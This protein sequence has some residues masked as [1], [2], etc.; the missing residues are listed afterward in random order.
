MT[1]CLLSFLWMALF[2]ELKK[3]FMNICIDSHFISKVYMCVWG[4]EGSKA[5]FKEYKHWFVIL[6]K[7]RRERRRRSGAV[8]IFCLINEVIECS[9]GGYECSKEYHGQHWTCMCCHTM[10]KIATH[11]E[12]LFK[13]SMTF[14]NILW[15][16]WVSMMFYFLRAS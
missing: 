8:T 15:Y 3:T 16:S 9:S 14:R 4:I 7:G 13:I 2:G 12:I 10:S 11:F 5:Y 1:N 6:R